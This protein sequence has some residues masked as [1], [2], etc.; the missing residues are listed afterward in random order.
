MANNSVYSIMEDKTG[1]LW[2]GTSGGVSRYDGKSFTNYTT[3]QGLANN[4]VIS[5]TED[6]T[7]NLW[8]GTAGGGVSR[9][10]GKSFTN[11]TTEQG[12][13]NNTVS[14]SR[15]IKQEISGSVHGWGSEP[16]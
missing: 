15:K 6:K 5:I 14:V 16:L 2:F 12:L 1:N 13:A 9:Y 8:F 4:I 10:D 7:G 11:F 3:A